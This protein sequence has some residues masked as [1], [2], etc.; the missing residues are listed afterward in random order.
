M[1]RIFQPQG[2]TQIFDR[3]GAAD[4]RGPGLARGQGQNLA[5]AVRRAVRR[6]DHPGGLAAP[7]RRRGLLEARDKRAF[8]PRTTLQT[9]FRWS[10]GEAW[11]DLVFTPEQPWKSG[12]VEQ[13]WLRRKE[14]YRKLKAEGK[15]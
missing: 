2:Q 5:A 4:F 8:A 11:K 9:P 1:Y 10:Q 13:D 7:D 15:V 14:A 12:E 6:L 3:E